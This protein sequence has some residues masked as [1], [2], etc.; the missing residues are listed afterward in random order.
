MRTTLLVTLFILI[1]PGCDTGLSP[2]N[3]PAGF[4]GVVRFKNWPPADSVRELRVVAFKSYPS[5]STGIVN[6][7]L[8]GDAVV[9]PAI[10]STGLPFYVDSVSYSFTTKG[11]TLQVETYDYVALA[12]RYGVNSFV[13]WRPAGVYTTTPGSFDPAPVHVLL[14]KIATNIDINVDFSN[15]P[16]TPWQ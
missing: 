12:W 3:E 16:P 1:V 13:D 6:A 5:D 8:A 9:Y 7:L 10:G 2:L 14:H 4:S 11:T 15:P